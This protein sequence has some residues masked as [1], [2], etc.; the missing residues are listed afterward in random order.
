MPASGIPKK[1]HAAE[2]SSLPSGFFQYFSS[3]LIYIGFCHVHTTGIYPSNFDVRYTAQKNFNWVL[4]LN[5][6]TCIF[7][8]FVCLILPVFILLLSYRK[9]LA[10]GIH[11]N[12]KCNDIFSNQNWE[13]LATCFI[14]AVVWLSSMSS[15]DHFR[16]ELNFSLSLP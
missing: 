16:L 1:I 12:S 7:Y 4:K 14:H 2:C 5:L 6:H 13:I 11:W 8:L 10:I 15:N 3:A 9:L